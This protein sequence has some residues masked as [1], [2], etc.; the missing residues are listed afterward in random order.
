[1]HDHDATHPHTQ[2]TYVRQHTR[3]RWIKRAARAGY[4]T[5]AALYGTIALLAFDAALVGG[6]SEGSRGAIETIAQQPLGMVML[7][8]I[9]VGLVAYALWRLAQLVVNPEQ[10]GW[11]VVDV[12]KR[13][14]ALFSALIH[15]SL[16][17]TAF[18]L[19]AYGNAAR[20]GGSSMRK[21]ATAWVLDV[22]WGRWLVGL[23][24]VCVAIAGAYQLYKAT[25]SDTIFKR[26]CRPRLGRK[27]RRLALWSGRF[28]L[29]SRGVVW[30][31]VGYFFL[32]AAVA[33]DP[34]KTG[35]LKH[36]LNSLASMD[37]GRMMLAAVAVGLLGYA[38][39]C[40][41]RARYFEFNVKR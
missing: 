32:H 1:M 6:S 12:A 27:E 38:W 25:Q 28:G 41:V 21:S 10:R 26:I 37:H 17:Y 30:L 14:T 19:L 4:A 34:D 3:R 22:T 23:F 36:A 18:T 40:A 31:M 39:F 7:G 24:G 29:T 20:S 16:A 33:F 8:L 2:E 9:G 11:G 5:K 35:G 15:A 13:A